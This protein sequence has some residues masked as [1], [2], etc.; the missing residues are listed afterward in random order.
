MW[1]L[2]DHGSEVSLPGG[3]ETIKIGYNNSDNARTFNF[4]ADVRPALCI[5]PGHNTADLE[6]IPAIRRKH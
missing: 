4:S 1:D 2:S 3:T 5:E 6:N